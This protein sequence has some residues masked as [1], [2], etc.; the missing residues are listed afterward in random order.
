MK[1]A[2][3]HINYYL[4]GIGNHPK[5]L[6]D[7][8]VQNLIDR[9]LIFSGGKRHYQLMKP[10]LPNEHVW[11][12]ISGGMDNVIAQYKASNQ[13]VVI[14]TSGDPFFYGFGNTLKRYLPNAKIASFPYFNS[15]QR[16]CHKTQTNY[17]EL[18]AVSV[19]GRDWHALNRVLIKN[20]PLIGVLTDN[21]K[22]PAVIAKHLLQ[23]GFDNYEICIGE[24]L[25]GD[26]EKINTYK[27]E[28][29]L[30][31]EFNPLN[32]LLL[33]KITTKTIP[34]GIPDNQ[35]VPLTNRSNMITK[36]PVRL[37]TV[38]ALNLNEVNTLWDIGSCTGS[39]AIESKRHFPHLNIVAFEKRTECGTIIQKNIERFSAP[40]IEIVIDDFFNLG[41]STFEIP[42]VVFIGGHGNR[43]AELLEK[44]VTLNPAIKIV[45]NAV[46]D[47]TTEVFIATLNALNYSISTTTIKVDEHNSIKIHSAVKLKINEKN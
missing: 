30:D 35:F 26:L 23:Y 27:L 44:I 36:M 3:T 41:L 25:D 5:P 4:I 7:E 39:V 14:F 29:V 8:D 17:N 28:V 46:K 37:S 21:R 12:E 1:E 32:C 24:A 22:T 2:S 42:E 19:H 11:I 33:R 18:T 38:H 20:K 16:L 10:L 15:I 13:S 40:G 45:I 31:L 43:L 9:S 6:I 47:T 34:F